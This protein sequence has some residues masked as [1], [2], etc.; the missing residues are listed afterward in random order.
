MDLTVARQAFILEPQ[1]NPMAEEQA[2]SRIHRMGQIKPVVTVRY[3]MQDSIEEVSVYLCCRDMI[4]FAE[5]LQ[6]IYELQRRKLKLAAL[7]ISGDVKPED[8]SYFEV[9]SFLLCIPCVL[10]Y[11]DI[12][13]TLLA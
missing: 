12:G 10:A 2:L 9:R 11:F 4:F 3:I 6:N 1:W 13:F 5:I 7:T 8:Y